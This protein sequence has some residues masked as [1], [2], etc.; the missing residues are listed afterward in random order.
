MSTEK[1]IIITEERIRLN[2]VDLN[3]TLEDGGL[4]RI[5]EGCDVRSHSQGNTIVVMVTKDTSRVK[6]WSDC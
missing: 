2:C 3:R 4:I 5:P 1:V 6:P